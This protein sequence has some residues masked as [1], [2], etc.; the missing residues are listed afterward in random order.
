MIAVLAVVVATAVLAGIVYFWRERLGAAGVGFTLLRTV[1]FGSLALALFNP[2]LFP[3]RT[4]GEATVL[5]D[6][7]LSM[8]AAGGAWEVALDSA[9]VLAG[10]GGVVRYVGLEA[11][12]DTVIPDGGTSRV[13]A[14]LR[15]AAG[16]SGPVFL[17]TDG[18]VDDVGNLPPSL[19]HGVQIVVHARDTVSDAA[20][21]DVQVPERL[22][23]TD[24]V[25][26]SVV[27]GTWGDLTA[28]TALLEVW[29]GGRR[30]A[31][32]TVELPAGEGVARR[33]ISIPAGVLSAGSHVL[34]FSLT[35]DGDQEPGDDERWRVVQVSDQAGV[36]VLVDPAD[37]EG[38]FLARELASVMQTGVTGYARIGADRW[39][40]MMTGAD[41]PT[42]FV[43][44]RAQRA[45]LLVVRGA[46]SP[47]GNRP[48]GQSRWNWPAGSDPGAELFEGDWYVTSQITASPLAAR[49]ATIEWDSLPPLTG[50]VPVVPAET[51]WVALAGRLGRRGGDQPLLIGG[52]SARQRSLTTASA[53]YWRWA[54]R[55]GAPR[56]AY[57]AVVSAGVDWLLETEGRVGATRLVASDVVPRGVPLV[58][59][60][61]G[62]DP[63]PDT[64]VVT[65]RGD[66]TSTHTLRFD[67]AGAARQLMPPGMYR[68]TVDGIAMSGVSVVEPYSDEFHP[69]PVTLASREGD[70][71]LALVLAPARESW[72]LFALAMLALIGEW[73]WRQRRGLP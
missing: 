55:G 3:Q 25:V 44:T 54:I 47:A 14:A 4:A 65:L 43:R 6:A 66:S 41:V 69:R 27:I 40:D 12:G 2:G 37:V 8:G 28:R 63:A 30:L 17:L 60:W 71:A 31:V 15:G 52:D 21:L 64:I 57:R 68:W 58:F 5:L 51:E 73:A 70:R 32:E 18:E 42:P 45:A 38:R 26:A 62:T 20:V 53:G 13:A 16:S 61:A 67:A 59:R 46:A 19:L 35:V 22:V 50:V 48:A 24:T 10:E 29:E 9:R 49:L 72:W 39:I 33:T 7:S 23:P 1:A 34:R 11:T 56:E 36:V